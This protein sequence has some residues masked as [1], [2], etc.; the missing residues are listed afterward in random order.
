[1]KYFKFILI[2][3][4]FL[5]SCEKDKETFLIAGDMNSI[6]T[7]NPVK[8]D[9]FQKTIPYWGFACTE[10][11]PPG[12]EGSVLKG[13]SCQRGAVHGCDGSVSCHAGTPNVIN[14]AFTSQE[15]IDWE[16]GNLEFEQ[17]KAWILDHYD[18]Y[19]EMYQAGVTYHPDTII[20]LNGW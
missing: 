2:F 5:A 13:V 12:T 18:F 20:A 17:N 11:P 19:I 4:V 15:I 8:N 14:S 6:I 3:T 16:N 7:A 1:M 9:K 10:P